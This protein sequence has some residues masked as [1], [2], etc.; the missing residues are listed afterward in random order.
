MLAAEVYEVVNKYWGI[1]MDTIKLNSKSLH[2]EFCRETGAL[3]R[4]TASETD[5]GIIDHP[6]LGLSFRLMV[7]LSEERRNN[8][9]FGEKQRLA[10]YKEHDGHIIFR[11]EGVTSELGGKL[12]INVEIKVAVE[13]RQIVYLMKI[14]NHSDYIIEA[15]YCPYLGDT[16]PPKEAEWFKSFI[17]DYGHCREGSLW[18]EFIN[19]TDYC[20]VDY[21]TQM[22][23]GA[24]MNPYYLLRSEKQGLYIGVKSNSTEF[25]AWSVELRPGWD[26][27]I[28]S[29]APQ[30]DELAGKP[31]HTP[32]AAVHMPYIQPG[33]NR[34]LTPIA[35]EAYQGGW[36]EGVDIYKAWR[37]SWMEPAKAP[38]WAKEPHSWLQLHINSPEDELRMR[39]TE[40]PKVAEEC[41]KHGVSVI[42]LV[43]WNDGGQDQGNPSHDPDPRLGTF[44]DLK[45][46][47]RQCHEIGV[48]V[49]IFTKFTWADQASDWFRTKLKELAVTDPYGDYYLYRG[50]SYFTPAQ[51]LDINTKR[52][53][54]MCFLSEEYLK[55]C[56]NEFKKV[57]DL[58]AA[59]MLFDEDQHHGNALLCFHSGHGH[60]YGAPVYQ[61]DRELI[62][63]FWK[64]PGISD[65]FLM[66]GEATYD[67]SM[68]AYQISYHRSESKWHV[69][70]SRYLLPHAQYMT[71]VTGFNDRNMINQC[72][73]CRY[74]ISYEPYFFKG[75]L[76]D[77]PETIAY[78]QKMDALRS[79]YRKWFW[80]GEYRDTCEVH[81]TATDGR[82]YASY[83][84]FKADDKSLGVVAVNYEDKPVSVTLEANNG[85]KFTKYQSVDGEKLL[86]FSTGIV[87]PARSAVIVMP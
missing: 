40:L 46:A 87:I 82:A 35:L 1:Y 44:E 54:P 74:I 16:R 43:G 78:G 36:Q 23:R 48:K 5:W 61:N 33:E 86:E 45:E 29:M 24:P 26:S 83:S 80:D 37:S 42:Q 38:E 64:T 27:S 4:L 32:F 60:R 50:Y 19:Q 79:K 11:W 49:I 31:V 65:D 22:E 57:V 58:G 81:V 84:V 18:P 6:E 20:G 15:A 9:V 63:R 51:L 8:N 71:A 75:M 47:I 2:C 41:K 69:A 10:S 25:V 68:E 56:E 21:P 3:V 66:A 28:N 34:T 67:W 30:T 62:K 77:Y 72:L 13:D 85:Q 14:D 52:L 17:Y 7:P 39:F 12:P 73:M 59:G 76:S 55:I 53:I 70:L